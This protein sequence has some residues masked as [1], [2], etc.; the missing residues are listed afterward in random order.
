MI[1]KAAV[2]AVSVVVA[3]VFVIVVEVPAEAE[4]QFA[5]VVQL[6][7]RDVMTFCF[8]NI[9]PFCFTLIYSR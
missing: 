3:V 1:I 6:L 2:A 8:F 4:E 9:S 5:A 7:R